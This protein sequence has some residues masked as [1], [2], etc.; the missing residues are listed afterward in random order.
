[1][2]VRSKRVEGRASRVISKFKSPNR[3]GGRRSA[4]MVGEHVP[5]DLSSANI[6]KAGE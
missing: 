1:V 6:W 4:D 3:G 2:V 5:F